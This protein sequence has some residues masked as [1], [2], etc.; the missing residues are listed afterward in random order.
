VAAL[1]E[2][3]LWRH[4]E[5]GDLPG[6]GSVVDSSKL[7]ELIDAN[8]GR[9]G[10]TYTHKWSLDTHNIISLAN[11]QGFTINVSCDSFEDIDR[12][13]AALKGRR[14][15]L[16]VVVPSDHPQF[17]ET[18]GGSKLVVCPNE[19]TGITCAE[20]ELCANPN[21]NSIVAFRAH[22]QSA[23][24]VSLASVQRRLPMLGNAYEPP[25]SPT[26]RDDFSK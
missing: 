7:T 19:T 13:R 18:P 5:A 20:C 4:N 22:G 8:F 3:Q 6:R 24:R 15:P 9:R 17:S 10:F 1:P 16:V 14:L 12:I 25:K 2:G 26:T 21:R 23:A 11:R